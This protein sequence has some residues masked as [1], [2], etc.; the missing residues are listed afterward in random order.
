MFVCLLYEVS[1]RF[2]EAHLLC[3]LHGNV[4]LSL[5]VKLLNTVRSLWTFETLSKIDYKHL[6][7]SLWKPPYYVFFFGFS[8]RKTSQLFL[9]ILR[10][11]Q[12][13]LHDTI[14]TTFCISSKALFVFHVTISLFPLLT[15]HILWRRKP[16][17]TVWK[18]ISSCRDKQ[19]ASLSFH[20][21]PFVPSSLFFL[22]LVV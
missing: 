20:S 15:Y 11:W 21:K 7:T 1:F 9:D 8:Q 17:L 5:S 12:L 19:S 16:A 18:A 14:I 3:P 22:L 4:K 6:V 2:E 10:D 13:L